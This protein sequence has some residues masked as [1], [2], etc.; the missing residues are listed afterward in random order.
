MAKDPH[1]LKVKESVDWEEIAAYITNHKHVEYGKSYK[2][3]KQRQ[4][5]PNKNK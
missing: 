5:F 2:S 3:T 1:R 4:I